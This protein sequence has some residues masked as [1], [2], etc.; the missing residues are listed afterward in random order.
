ML[1][2]VYASWQQAAWHGGLSLTACQSQPAATKLLP[3]LLQ[4]LL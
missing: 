3:S 2:G 1:G 4:E